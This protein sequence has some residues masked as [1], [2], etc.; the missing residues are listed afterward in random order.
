MINYREKKAIKN[1]KYL[2]KYDPGMTPIGISSGYQPGVS[3][4]PTVSVEQDPTTITDAYK[5]QIIPSVISN[6]YPSYDLTKGL[7]KTQQAISAAKKLSAAETTAKSA[8]EIGDS[9]ANYTALGEA[10]EAGEKVAQVGTPK[11]AMIASKAAA[12]LATVYGGYKSIAAADEYGRSPMS[13]QEMLGL[14][15]STIN[16]ANGENWKEMTLPNSFDAQKMLRRYNNLGMAESISSAATFGQGGGTLIGSIFGPGGSVVGSFAGTAL[17]LLGGWAL[18][19]INRGK[20]KRKFNQM[21]QNL[22]NGI[23]GY[24][25]QNEA[26]AANKGIKNQFFNEHSVGADKGLNLNS[27]TPNGRFGALEQIIETDNNKNV[28]N[29][30]T[31]PEVPGIHDVR[32]DS[33]IGEADDNTGV[34]GWK[35]DEKTGLPFTVKMAPVVQAFNSTN[36]KTEKKAIGE[37]MKKELV[38]QEHTPNNNPSPYDILGIDVLNADKGKNMKKYNCGK[39]LKKCDVGDPLYNRYTGRDALRASNAYNIFGGLLGAYLGHKQMSEAKAMQ[40]IVRDSYEADPGEQSALNSM[41]TDVKMGPLFDYINRLSR[42]EDYFIKNRLGL[43]SGQKLALGEQA[44]INTLQAYQDA[45]N[46]KLEL[47]GQLI[48][49]K[50]KQRLSVGAQNAERK[51][52]SNISKN[53]YEAKANAAQYASIWEGYRNQYAP[54][55]SVLQNAHNNAWQRALN[56]LYEQQLSNEQKKITQNAGTGTGSFVIPSLSWTP[57]KSKYFNTGG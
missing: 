53:D 25:R 35:I 1:G 26:I 41:P 50:A 21:W 49:D 9:A 2:P 27:K 44:Y 40:R 8:A 38:R 13:G 48:T 28:V 47:Q 55:L 16:Q 10:A 36:N 45:Y 56:E 51:M 43:S 29:A 54:I 39:G 3:Y 24:N 17:G 34:F 52:R 57:R 22:E 15:G 5:E 7:F 12:G 37:Y 19:L 4:A 11:A 42:S 6:L 46:K 14:T 30:Y 23:E 18:G 31:L 20:A 33:Y 32:A